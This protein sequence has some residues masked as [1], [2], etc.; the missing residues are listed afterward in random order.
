M[1]LLVSGRSNVGQ[2]MNGV[3]L[4]F[5][6]IVISLAMKTEQG[7]GV[8]IDTIRGHSNS[9]WENDP[10][11]VNTL[12]NDLYLITVRSFIVQQLIGFL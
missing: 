4:G 7:R 1:D 10:K 5:G 6:V 11:S 8:K 3:G 2:F 9:D 12:S